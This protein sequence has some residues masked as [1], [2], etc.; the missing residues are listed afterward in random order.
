[1]LLAADKALQAKKTEAADTLA[2]HALE[3]AYAAQLEATGK[4]P[5]SFKASYASL[6]KDALLEPYLTSA[7]KDVPLEDELISTVDRWTLVGFSPS[8]I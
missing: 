6:T 4:K 3:R 5:P 1:M 8:S 7:N 2:D